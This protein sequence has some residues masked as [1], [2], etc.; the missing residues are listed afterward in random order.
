MNLLIRR[1]SNSIKTLRLSKNL[2]I[3]IALAISVL[4]CNN[5]QTSSIE[6]NG[7]TFTL[8][9]PSVEVFKALGPP[10]ATGPIPGLGKYEKWIPDNEKYEKWVW[11]LDSDLP[12][13]VYLK[14]GK[15]IAWKNV[16]PTH[17]R[18][19]KN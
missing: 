3:S 4:G 10:N 9:S 6:F 7:N 15:V 13:T 12:P 5:S 16:D 17:I 14:E 8:G 19:W 11:D 2:L 1:L 18:P